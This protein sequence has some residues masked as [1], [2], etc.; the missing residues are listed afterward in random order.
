MEETLTVHRLHLPMQL[1]KTMA[2]TNVIESAF[3][4]VESQRETLARRWPALALGRLWASGRR[5]AIPQT[6]GIQADSDAHRGGGWQTE[7][8]VVEWVTRESRLSTEFRVS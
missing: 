3:S 6:A 7:T 2:G 1:C 4:I 8:G 5:K